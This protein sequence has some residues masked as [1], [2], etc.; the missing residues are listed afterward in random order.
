LAERRSELAIVI[1]HAAKPRI[2]EA[3]GFSDWVAGMTP[4]SAL[5]N[6][7]CKLS[8]LL[9]E[10]NGCPQDSI[11]P[12]VEALLEL[13]GP[14]RLMWGS[15]WPVLEAAS[16]YSAWLEMAQRLVPGSAHA[17]V[18]ETTARDFYGLAGDGMPH[19]RP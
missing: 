4:L 6:V 1:D 5:P 2:D 16:Y 8:G 14:D 9:T 15:D 13:F 7:H 12:Y 3:A 10:C 11:A 19:D 17:A 18:F